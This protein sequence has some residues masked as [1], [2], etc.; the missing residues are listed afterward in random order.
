MRKI[1]VL[2]VLVCLSTA[3]NAR[4]MSGRELKEWV[5]KY[6]SVHGHPPGV[7]AGLLMGYVLGI[8][9]TGVATGVICP[10]PTRFRQ[11]TDVV[12]KYLQ[13]HPDQLGQPAREVA[14]AALMSAYPCGKP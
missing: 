9:D 11:T 8:L 2:A 6:E 7:E 13:A 12:V 4:V 10:P 14:L 5:P 3:A 1:L